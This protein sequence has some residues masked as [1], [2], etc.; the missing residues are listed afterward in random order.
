MCEMP[1]EAPTLPEMV[2]GSEFLMLLMRCLI[3]ALAG[4]RATRSSITSNQM[5]FVCENLA[6]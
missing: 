4:I 1:S 6:I 2:N 3:C 5:D